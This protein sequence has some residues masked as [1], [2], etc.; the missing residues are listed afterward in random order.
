M[1]RYIKWY[2]NKLIAI[3]LIT[4]CESEI[5]LNLAI[6]GTLTTS[7]KEVCRLFESL[8]KFYIPVPVALAAKHSP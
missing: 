4:S 3:S 1:H 7:H 2:Y 8:V 6:D 5:V